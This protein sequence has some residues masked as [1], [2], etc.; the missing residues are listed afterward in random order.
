M[1]K[2]TPDQLDPLPQFLGTISPLSPE[3][4]QFSCSVIHIFCP[5]P[6]TA[7]LDAVEQGKAHNSMHNISGIMHKLSTHGHNS[8]SKTVAVIKKL[9]KELQEPLQ[10]TPL[11]LRA[12]PI[13][14]PNNILTSTIALIHKDKGPSFMH[15]GESGKPKITKSG[16]PMIVL[17]IPNHCVCIHDNLLLDY[18]IQGTC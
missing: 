2:W 14:T 16:T 10:I 13:N 5:Q 3:I 4:E 6:E 9:Y 18:S 8:W 7:K 12:I 17:L 1:S 11:F 15:K